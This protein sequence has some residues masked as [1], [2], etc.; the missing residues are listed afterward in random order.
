MPATFT[1]DLPDE[2]A[3]VLGNGVEDEVAVDRESAVSNYG[4]VRIQ[5]RETGQSSWDS[6]ATGFGEFIGSYDTITMEFVG[7]KDGEEYEVRA[8]TET[9]HVIGA[10]TSPV[11]IV[12]VFPGATNLTVDSST[13]SSVTI[14]WTDNADNESGTYV[15]RRDELDPRRD[16]G[17][18]DWV[19]VADLPPD[20]GDTNTVEYVDDGDLEQN[21]DYE[22]Y[23]EPYTEYKSAQSSS[24]STTTSVAVPGE[25]WFIVLERSDGEKAT[26]P[27]DIVDAERASLEPEM[28]AVARW[29]FDLVPNDVLRDWLRSEALIYYEGALWLRGPYTR[30]SPDGGAS[31]AAARIEGLGSFDHLKSGAYSYDVVSEPGHEA[32][33][34]FVDENLDDWVADVTAPANDTVDEGWLVQDAS[35]ESEFADEFGT[36]PD[37]QPYTYAGGDLRPEIAAYHFDARDASGSYNEGN[38]SEGGSSDYVDGFTTLLESGSDYLEASISLDYTIPSEYV[39]VAIRQGA[40][41]APAMTWKLDG[42]EMDSLSSSTGYISFGWVDQANNPYNG[43]GYTGGDLS[44]T[45]DVRIE[46]DGAGSDEAWAADWIVLYDT[47]YFDV[48]NFDDTTDSNDQLSGPN[49]YPVVDIASKRFSQEYNVSAATLDISVDDTSGKQRLQASNDA[50]KTWLPTDGTESSTASISVD[51][52]ANDLYGTGVEGRVTLGAYGSRTGDTPTEG[53]LVQ[54]VSSWKLRI[55]TTSLR[56]IDDQTFTGSAYEILDAIADESNM[57]YVPDYRETQLAMDAFQPGDV[58]RDVAWTVEDAQPVDTTEGYF[59]KVTIFGPEQDDGTRLTA[60]AESSDE[61]AEKGEV[62]GPA[63]ERPD[64]KTKEELRSIARTELQ[65]GLANDTVTGKLDISGQFVQP[66]YA[67]SVDKFASFDERTDPAYV[68]QSASYSWG[69]MKL[70]FEGRNSLAR[71]IRSIETE[72]RTTKR[73]V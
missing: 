10:W 17:F 20:S 28:S 33:G 15:Y 62:V 59:N 67:Y 44:G 51:F 27:H 55:D 39:G 13:S 69:T 32:F 36:I 48:A 16:T 8:R 12:T 23:V 7:R 42:N 53:Y 57:V 14:S 19:V 40:D 50:G 30:Y 52:E 5:I 65:V 64:A 37:D 38:R 24:V 31:E 73:A 9:E 18:G 68:L 6:N 45:V 26:V 56:V 35:T 43:D 22:Y 34:R 49:E 21:H 11:S 61:I 46:C 3:P 66:G 25:G 41:D 1:T 2:D 60:T 4:D 71:T 58:V 72:V 70:D 47:R 63:K 29:S 54:T